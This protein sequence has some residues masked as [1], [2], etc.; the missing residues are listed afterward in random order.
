MSIEQLASSGFT[1]TAGENVG[2]RHVR[3][4][5]Q[6]A[7]HPQ[8]RGQL[9]A[10]GCLPDAGRVA[11]DRPAQLQRHRLDLTGPQ[12][13]GRRDLDRDELLHQAGPGGEVRRIVPVERRGLQSKC[14]NGVL[15]PENC[16]G[17]RRWIQL[18]FDAFLLGSTNP[19]MVVR[20]AMLAADIMRFAAR[21]SGSGTRSP[22]AASASSSSTNGTGRAAGVESDQN[23]L[24]DSESPTTP[25]R[26]SRSRRASLEPGNPAVNARV[27]VGHYEG[28]VSP[29][30]D[31][32]PRHERAGGVPG[33]QPGRGRPVR[34]RDVRVRRDR[35]ASATSA[36]G[37]PSRTGRRR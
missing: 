4:R 33:E 19:S 12:V 27:Y 5:Q 3:D 28:R 9:P 18:L 14:V 6:G 32:N 35:T 17:N 2:D 25:V 29:I 31:T 10:D 36:S 16:S 21:T 8:L 30:A 34:S 11:A 13:R 15:P 1:P 23:P 24:P 26:R 22:R 20:N 37:R 7:R